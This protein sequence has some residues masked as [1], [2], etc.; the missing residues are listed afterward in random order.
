MIEA[1]HVDGVRNGIYGLLTDHLDC[2]WFMPFE[3]GQEIVANADQSA[4]IGQFDERRE[5]SFFSANGVGGLRNRGLTNRG[6][7][8]FPHAWWALL[9]G[10]EELYEKHPEWWAR[11]R[12]GKIRK[13]DTGHSW[14]NFCSTDPQVLEIVADYASWLAGKRAQYA[15]PAGYWPALL[16][17][18]YFAD[19][20]RFVRNARKQLANPANPPKS[21]ALEW[22]VI[23]PFDNTAR[24][25]FEQ[26]YCCGAKVCGRVC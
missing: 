17:G 26:V 9:R 10:T 15:E 11:D 4:V 20:E 13:N 18:Y 12:E 25:G 6:R 5:P 23:G 16:P 24:K 3:L 21:L 14:T 7:M 8:S 1:G 22:M 2:H 19:L